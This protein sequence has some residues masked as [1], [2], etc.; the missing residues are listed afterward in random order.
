MSAAFHHAFTIPAALALLPP[1]MTSPEAQAMLLA[2]GFQESRF[3]TRRQIG[4]PARG[5]WQFELAGGV[6]GVLTH[7]V[8]KPTIDHV[9]D[10]LR[11]PPAASACYDAIEHN[12]VLAA[13]FARL[14][15]YTA[16]ARL[17]GPYDADRAWR[18]Y[19]DT[20]RPGKPHHESW[21]NSYARA[22][23]LVEPGPLE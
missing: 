4:G 2:I 9:L 15:L 10:E 22:W 7:P 12:D 1:T 19:E 8:T 17:P 11:Y 23:A 20:W 16:P 21:V 3:A 18:I 6:A 5:F 13:I 14:L